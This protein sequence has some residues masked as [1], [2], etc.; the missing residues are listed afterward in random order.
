[1]S[2]LSLVAILAISVLVA[3]GGGTD[4]PAPTPAPAPES[5]P[6]PTP[7]PVPAPEPIVVPEPA[8]EP[9]QGTDSDLNSNPTVEE[10]DPNS[11]VDANC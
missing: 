8:K 2:L 3:C 7:E 6:A 11:N 5:T 1:M 4:T 10:E 9:A